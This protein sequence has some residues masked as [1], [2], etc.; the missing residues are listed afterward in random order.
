TALTHSSYANEYKIESNERL[1]FLGD[2]VLG[3]ITSEY[4]YKYLDLNEGK[5]SKL[6][7]NMVCWQ[8]LSK[9]LKKMDIKDK[10]KLGNSLKTIS[11]SMLA[12]TIESMI[13]AIYLKHGLNKTRDAVLELLNVK[14]Y[15]HSNPKAID[16]KTELQEICQKL[17]MKVR[18]DITNYVTKGGQTNF[19][20]KIYI[21]DV[22]YGYG[23][24]SLKKEAE[25]NSAKIA[26]SKLEKHNV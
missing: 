16:F 7:A 21:D 1:E 12:D 24:G 25:Q 10:L 22:F 2:S 15:L 8:N 5:M 19:R 11:D 18:Y 23:T 9:I 26:I 14:E 20:S 17:K 13:G 4:M 6:R 3:L